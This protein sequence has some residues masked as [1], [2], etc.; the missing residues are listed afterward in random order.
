MDC[1]GCC[2]YSS[3]SLAGCCDDTGGGDG[4]VGADEAV[5]ADGADGGVAFAECPGSFSGSISMGYSS[6]SL[7]AAGWADEDEAGEG[8]NLLS[9]SPLVS[10]GIG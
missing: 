9:T 5:G 8:C 4:A 3:S 7:A 1:T 6:S 10:L 2:G